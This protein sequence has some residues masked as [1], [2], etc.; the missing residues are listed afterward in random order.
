MG[1]VS[2]DLWTMIFEWC[3]LIIL[4]VLLKK[5]LFGRVQRILDQRDEEISGIYAE[6]RKEQEQAE[7]LREEY[8][9]KIS[10]ARTDA[11]QMRRSAM[12][13]AS[14]MKELLLTEAK[15]KADRLVSRGEEQT[16]REREEAMEQLKA[17]VSDMAVSIAGKILQREISRKEHEEMIQRLIEEM[18]EAS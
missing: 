13:E 4:C 16:A 1:F 6:A 3:N 8:T 18:E 14:Q 9:R 7:R 2:I 10:D 17:E 15:E 11:E 5:L 12:A